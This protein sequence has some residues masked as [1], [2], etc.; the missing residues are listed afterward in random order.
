MKTVE[1]TIVPVTVGRRRLKIH[2][3][4][5]TFHQEFD[6]G[7]ASIPVILV[8][9][10]NNDGL[11]QGRAVYCRQRLAYGPSHG[12]LCHGPSSTKESKLHCSKSK[13]LMKVQ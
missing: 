7:T 13:F 10:V 2:C 4:A 1:V 6:F 5:W 8:T 3:E 9:D 12:T 11:G